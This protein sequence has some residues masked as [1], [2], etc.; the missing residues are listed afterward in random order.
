M[1]QGVGCG[2]DIWSVRA[3]APNPVSADVP[4]GIDDCR[5]FLIHLSKIPGIFLVKINFPV[6][7]MFFLDFLIYNDSISPVTTLYINFV[8]ARCANPSG[9]WGRQIH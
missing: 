4:F 8:C 6:K 3:G 7:L 1:G 9:S 5:A 2:V